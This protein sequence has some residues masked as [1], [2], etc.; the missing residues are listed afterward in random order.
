MK[1]LIVKEI[2]LGDIEIGERVRLV[3]PAHVAILKESIEEHNGLILPIEVRKVGDTYRL[4]SGAHR[5]AAFNALG[6]P[7]IPAVVR[8]M[9]D[10]N[11]ARL[12]EIDENLVRHEL[13]PLDRAMFLAERKRIYDEQHPD[14][15]N[16]GDRKSAVFKRKN[17][18]AKVAIWSFAD[19][20][21][22]QTGLGKRTIY[23]FLDIANNLQRRALRAR[24]TGAA[25]DTPR[26]FIRRLNHGRQPEESAGPTF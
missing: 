25:R 19:D 21:A 14:T 7:K 4:V 5:L 18:S 1:D 15:K 22:E 16:G 13:N 3:D 24:K 2:A 17:Q 8:R 23:R 10:N 12:R 6:W 20:T 11:E 9:K 26:P